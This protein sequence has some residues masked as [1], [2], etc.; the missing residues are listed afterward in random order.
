LVE[1]VLLSTVKRT[2]L[3]INQRAVAVFSTVLI[4]KKQ[5]ICFFDTALNWLKER[6]MEAMDGP[7][8]F[9][10][11]DKNWG[12]LIDGFAQQN[13]GMLYNAPYYQKLYENYGFG[14]TS[15]NTL[16]GEMYRNEDF[17][18]RFLRAGPAGVKQP[19]HHIPLHQKERL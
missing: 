18:P 15:N 13:Y 14:Y 16:S 4:I 8:N 10:E 9:G 6:G 2:I 19:G 7:V 17:E 12:V 5:P 1:S 11:R 3:K